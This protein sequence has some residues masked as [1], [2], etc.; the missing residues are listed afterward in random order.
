MVKRKIVEIDEEKCNGCGQCIP[1][2]HEGALQLIDGKAK[3]VSDVYCDGLGNCIG[4]CPQDA[5]MIIEKDVHEFDFEKTN[6]HL[7]ELGKDELTENPL[8]NNAQAKPSPCSCPGA[9][10][11]QLKTGGNAGH[12]GSSLAQ[13]PVQMKLLPPNAPFFDNSHLLVSADCVPFANPNFHSQLLNGKSLAIG[14][15]KLD[16][17]GEYK[18]KLTEIFKHNRIKSVTVAIMEVPCCSGLYEAVKEAVADSGK[19]IP[20]IREVVSVSG[21]LQ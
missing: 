1:N 17:T 11:R 4:H 20:I 15:P 14:C 5:I 13:W 21:E 12:G 16:D 3:L 7:K 10:V 9:A 18:E 8:A 6:E 19:D 2:C